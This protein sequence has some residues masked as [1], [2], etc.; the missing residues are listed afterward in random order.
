MVLV[1]LDENWALR[2]AFLKIPSGVFRRRPSPNPFILMKVG[3]QGDSEKPITPCHLKLAACLA[4]ESFLCLT[5]P[6]FWP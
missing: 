5:V 4:L 1:D 3:D 2:G 6:G